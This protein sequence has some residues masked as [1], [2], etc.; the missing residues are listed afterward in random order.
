MGTWGTGIF[1]NDT[2]CDFAAAVASGGGMRALDDAIE[3]VLLSEG[4]YLEA[5]DAA[6]GLAAA[7]IIARL[8]GGNGSQT[9]YTAALDDWIKEAQ[10]QVP[11]ELVDRAKRAISRILSEPSELLELWTESEELDGWKGAIAAITQRL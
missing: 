5:P 1:E 3:R 6:E 10:V 11:D 7:E 9:A 4:N 2:S 8:R